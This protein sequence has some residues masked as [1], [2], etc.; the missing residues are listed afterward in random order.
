MSGAT[1]S[2][3]DANLPHS[4]GS[5]ARKDSRRSDC[6]R[7]VC[8]DFGKALRSEEFS[9]FKIRCGHKIFP[10]H[11]LMLSARSPVFKAMFNSNMREAT[12]NEVTITDFDPDVID[13]MLQF[14]YAGT[15][16]KRYITE[17]I[18]YD[19]LG[20]ANKYQLEL[21]K[22][23]CEDKL[24]ESL[25][26]GNSMKYL[27]LSDLQGAEKLREMSMTLIVKN[28]DLIMD[29]AVYRNWMD[30]HKHLVLEITKMLVQR[31]GTKRT[32]V[33]SEHDRDALSSPDFNLPPPTPISANWANL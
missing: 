33:D 19:L 13:K 29:T 21:L 25:D 2:D 6:R 8:E 31:A 3:T 5:G 22:N 17:N 15:F 1:N 23:K 12:N 4:S 24:C 18:A 10:C 11:K 26:I 30:T 16:E 28:M 20:A 27:V 14:I 9:D 32:R 7:Q